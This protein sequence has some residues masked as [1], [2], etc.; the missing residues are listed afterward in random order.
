MR[1]EVTLAEARA[2][3]DEKLLRSVAADP[4]RRQPFLRYHALRV[5]S[6][7]VVTQ[8][9]TVGLV[10]SYAGQRFPLNT[11]RSSFPSPQTSRTVMLCASSHSRTLAHKQ[12][13]LCSQAFT[14]WAGTT[15][16]E[17]LLRWAASTIRARSVR[18][19]RSSVISSVV[20]MVSLLATRPSSLDVRRPLTP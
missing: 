9:F 10:S 14:L 12:G 15:R 19:A 8:A 16:R 6:A 11:G 17:N 13:S 18:E 2:G 20:V 5:S 1:P 7:R 3:G 4:P